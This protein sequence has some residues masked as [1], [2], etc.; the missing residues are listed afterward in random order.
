MFFFLKIFLALQDLSCFYMNFRIFFFFDFWSPVTGP[1]QNLQSDLVWRTHRHEL[2]DHSQEGL[3]PVHRPLQGP[4]PGP[5][6]VH[7]TPDLWV[8]LVP[9]L[10]C[11]ADGRTKPNGAAA[12]FSGGTELSLGL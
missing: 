3:E 12:E 4:R 8:G 5:R 10:A 11:G 9:P 7:L 1:C 6:S 2:L